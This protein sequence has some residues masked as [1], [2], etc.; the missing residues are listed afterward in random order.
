MAPRRAHATHFTSTISHPHAT[1]AAPL[2][3]F[4]ALAAT[5]TLAC[6]QVITP[7]VG[8][9]TA[10]YD[11]I[12]RI[13]PGASSHFAL[14][15]GAS[16]PGAGSRGCFT[17]ADAA[18][19]TLAIAGTTASDVAAGLG[20]YLRDIC[21]MTT[22]WE[23]GGGSNYFVPTSW[24]VLGGN[25]TRARATPWSYQQNVCTHS[26]SLVWYDWAAWERYIDWSALTGIN[27]MLGM[28]GA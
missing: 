6:A 1:H 24:P 25:L 3:L 5:A 10:V 9:V 16:C 20:H 7:P 11:L 28:T 18:G 22:G 15:L 26:Y 27:M 8:N 21:N 19:G 23:H 17:L 13:L 4:A 14:T 2:Q 12:E